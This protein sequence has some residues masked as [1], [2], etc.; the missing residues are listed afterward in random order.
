MPGLDGER[1]F[2]KGCNELH[3]DH[4]VLRAP[5]TASARAAKLV[6]VPEDDAF[7]RR[8]LPALLPATDGFGVQ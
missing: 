3:P 2:A 6:W 1:F 4:S 7:S 8:S 5:L